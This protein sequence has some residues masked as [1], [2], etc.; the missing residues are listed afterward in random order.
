[1]SFDYLVFSFYRTNEYYLAVTGF[2]KTGTKTTGATG[3][4]AGIMTGFTGV[5]GTV[6]GG[7]TT[8]F[9]GVAGTVIGGITTG[10]GGVAGVV[11]AADAVVT[12]A[13][14]AIVAVSVL[15]ITFFSCVC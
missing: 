5:A 1:L 8:G 13:S 7:I 3:T 11:V 4:G 6:I 2:A 14:N 10:F 15:I 12:K 9:T